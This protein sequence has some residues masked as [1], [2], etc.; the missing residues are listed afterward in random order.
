M[1]RTGRSNKCADAMS[2]YPHE[3][4][5]VEV[6]STLVKSNDCPSVPVMRLED[7]KDEE[8]PTQPQLHGPQIPAVFPSFSQSQLAELQKDDEESSIVW[9]CWLK[10]WCPGSDVLVSRRSRS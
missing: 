3:V 8:V 7:A 1:Y 6:R 4:I 5:E 9:D 10:D 2:R